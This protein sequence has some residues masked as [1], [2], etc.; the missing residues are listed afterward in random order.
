MLKSSNQQHIQYN[1]EKAEGKTANKTSTQ[2]KTR[3][4]K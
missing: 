3:D 2:P 4:K 1:N